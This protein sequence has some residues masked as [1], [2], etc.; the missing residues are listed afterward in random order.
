VISVQR[1]HNLADNPPL[2]ALLGGF[3][4]ALPEDTDDSLGLYEDG[5]L[6]GCGFL[7]GTML[8]GLAIDGERQ[9]EGLSAVLVTGLVKLAARR[10]IRHLRI[11]TKPSMAAPL[12]SLGMSA[13]ADA[14]PY[15]VF[16]E[17]GGPGADAR[18][19]EFRA[20][21]ADRPGQA[22]CLV[23]NCNPFTW[24]HRRLI[25]RAAAENPWAWVLVVEEDASAFSF[26]DRL[27]LVREGT[28]DLANVQ[29]IP[30][31]A[32]V[33]SS[34][35][36]PAYFTRDADLAAAQ[37][38]LDAAVFARLV[39]PALKVA[40]RYVG[41]EPLSPK[42]NLYNQAL[43]ERLPPAGVELVEIPR[44]ETGGA[45]ISASAVRE[46]LKNGDWERV[47]TLTPDATWNFLRSPGAADSIRALQSGP[48]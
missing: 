41:S 23:M 39:A 16:L 43:R 18:M 13:V 31:G 30:G 14:S 42:T 9:G 1:I 29:V 8:Q 3:D 22:A 26:Q 24:G 11:I 34:L 15:A 7:K 48:R 46:A 21:A 36:F 33:I 35:T 27:R 5:K 32:Y 38:A 44:V 4:L 6:I 40:R 47:R 28:A 19:D 2:R 12:G 25:E 37:G 20:L 17:F 45:A 10:G